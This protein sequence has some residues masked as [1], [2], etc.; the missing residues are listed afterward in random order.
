V[1]VPVT[2]GG[3]GR[4]CHLGPT[5]QRLKKGRGA[6]LARLAWLLGSAAGPGRDSAGRPTRA[7]AG[8]QAVRRPS[9][10]EGKKVSCFSLFFSLLVY[11]QKPFQIEF[12]IQIKIK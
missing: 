9:G 2:T 6:R 3:R 5:R 12:Q 7:D 4:G 11:F 10:Q 1:S 8:E